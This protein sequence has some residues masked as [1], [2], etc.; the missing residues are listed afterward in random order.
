MNCTHFYDIKGISLRVED[1]TKTKMNLHCTIRRMAA[2][3]A[4]PTPLL[5]FFNNGKSNFL[6][7]YF[8]GHVEIINNRALLH[9]LV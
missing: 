4:C 8:E 9:F 5:A 7:I 6:F 3:A 1:Y 2:E